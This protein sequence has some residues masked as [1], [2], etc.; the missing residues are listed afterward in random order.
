MLAGVLCEVHGSP[1]KDK[2]SVGVRDVQGVP[3][4]LVADRDFL[5]EESGKHYLPIGVV[6]QDERKGVALIE[7]PYEADSGAY[8][9][10][11]PVTSLLEMREAPL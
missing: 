3:T 6:Y 9:I 4:Y 10:W 5:T 7:F 2:V 11:V 1:W 8:R